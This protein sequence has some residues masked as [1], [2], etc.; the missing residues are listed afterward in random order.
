MYGCNA[1]SIAV[2]ENELMLSAVKY[3]L[4]VVSIMRFLI[5]GLNA[6]LCTKIST[7]PKS[8]PMALASP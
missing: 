1:L 4:R 3:A 7:A 6:M 5:S 2:S 8:L